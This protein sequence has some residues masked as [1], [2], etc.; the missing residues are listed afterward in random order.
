[1]L[2]AASVL[3][4]H[5]V[6]LLGG[7]CR[8]A[9]P[10]VGL[11]LLI[12]IAGAAIQLPGRATTAAVILAAIVLAAAVIV[13]RAGSGKEW[14]R[15]GSGWLSRWGLPRR[16]VRVGALV[17]PTSVIAL[18][19]FGAAVPFLANGWVGLLGVSLDND[20]AAHMT[21]TQGLR[22]PVTAARYGINHGYPLGP[23]SLVGTL[24]T[25][26]GLRLDLA[27]TA[28]LVAAVVLIAL[29]GAIALRREAP[30]K[31][32]IAGVLSGLFYLVAAYYAEGAFKEP[33]MGLFLLGMVVQ[34][35]ELR[36]GWP[37]D[38][39]AR[40]RALLPQGVIWAGAMWTYSYT[41]IAW[42]GGTV[43]I[44]AVA[45]ALVNRPGLRPLWRRAR[46]LALPILAGAV[47][48]VLLLLPT[49]GRIVS[50]VQ[51]LGLSPAGTGAI[52]ASNLGNLAHPLSAYEALGIWNIPDFRL[53][54]LNVFHQGEL[55]ALA[56]L[57]LALGLAWSLGRRQ[58][59]LPAAVV[60]CALI[61]WHSNGVQSPY[62]TAKALV[63]AG[64]VVAVCGIRGL[65]G[66]TPTRLPA[67]IAL[68]RFALACA[69]VY[70]ACHSGYE[71]LRNEPVWSPE[72]TRE[73]LALD[74]KVRGQDVLFLG[75]RI[76][77]PGSSRIRI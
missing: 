38:G 71:A 43:A 40:W 41:A 33:L 39:R 61:Y 2:V 32:V 15:A 62:V 76:T 77:P 34:L 7:R 10:A 55:S 6:N 70:L 27:M 75:A 56:L 36:Q 74:Q 59:V 44:W 30:W 42:F 72:P 20:T 25:A 66:T 54:P 23:H 22:T 68:P 1:M 24:A 58:L 51:S 31:R 26:L 52:T 73:L 63:I 11:A 18:S 50:Y 67:W 46:E 5:A 57:V 17:V 16:Q 21:W 9:A 64:P 49:A 37:A 65:L 13:V 53:L 8:A 47:L 48:M 4:G 60:A 14:A 3:V 45:E 69:F 29:V 12:A 28:L 19:A 35:E